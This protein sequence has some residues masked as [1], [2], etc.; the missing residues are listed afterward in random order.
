[1]PL[2]PEYEDQIKSKIADLKNVGGRAGGSITAA[3]FL[4]AFVEKVGDGGRG[5]RVDGSTRTRVGS[6]ARGLR[7]FAEVWCHVVSPVPDA[8]CSLGL[9][10]PPATG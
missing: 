8:R 6:R 9:R 5:V 4:K 3:M 10:R 2:V 7:W 1:M